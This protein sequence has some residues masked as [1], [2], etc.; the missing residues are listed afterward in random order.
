MTFNP[1]D[2]L[3]VAK[4]ATPAEIKRAYRKRAKQA[5]PDK[6]GTS[7]EFTRLAH[8]QLILLDPARR[9]KF[10]ST[11]TIDPTEPDNALSRA[12]SILVGFLASVVQQHVVSG[13]VDPT[14]VDLVEQARKAFKQNLDSF[15]KEMKKIERHAEKLA[16]VEKRL[17]TRKKSPGSDLLRQALLMQINTVRQPL[18]AIEMNAQGFG[19]ALLLLDDFVFDVANPDVSVNPYI[20]WTVT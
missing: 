7:E 4:T 3:D 18:H 12:V 17:R 15:A 6:G 16:A 1:Y 14:K 5:H 19:D 10:D 13:G 11:G 20:R 9:A 2:V 8:S